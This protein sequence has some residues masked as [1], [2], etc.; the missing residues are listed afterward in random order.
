MI[1]ISISKYCRLSYQVCGRLAA[2]FVTVH[3]NVNEVVWMITHQTIGI[4]L[5]LRARNRYLVR[6]GPSSIIVSRTFSH[7]FS[8]CVVGV[9]PIGLSNFQTSMD[10]N[11]RTNKT[12]L[13]GMGNYFSSIAR[14]KPPSNVNNKLT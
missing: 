9:I 10:G 3:M 1:K 11:I 8:F 5:K 12:L 4:L 13:T 6:R 2:I 7:F 14:Y